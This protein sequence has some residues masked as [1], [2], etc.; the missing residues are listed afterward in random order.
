MKNFFFF[1]YLSY[2]L[3]LILCI[4]GIHNKHFTKE[5]SVFELEGG[6][7]T[8]A[9]FLSISWKIP[10]IW[11]EEFNHSHSHNQVILF[12]DILYYKLWKHEVYV[13]NWTKN[14]NNKWHYLI[15]GC[16]QGKVDGS[17]LLVNKNYM[18][19]WKCFN[20]LKV[21]LN[22]FILKNYLH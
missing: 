10:C 11:I 7:I 17:L 3:L 15:N 5:L 21:E 12:H 20:I 1:F 19:P 9:C 2:Q 8:K 22:K 16:K 4:H 18:W 13:K 6:A 14:Y